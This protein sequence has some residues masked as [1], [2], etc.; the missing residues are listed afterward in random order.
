MNQLLKIITILSLMQSIESIGLGADLKNININLTKT[1]RETKKIQEELEKKLESKLEDIL[2]EYKKSNGLISSDNFKS[3]YGDEV[4]KMIRSAVQK[5]YIA[6]SN[7]VGKAINEKEIFL[8]DKD[9]ANIKQEANRISNSFWYQTNQMLR[10]Y[11]LNKQEKTTLANKERTVTPAIV[12]S[13]VASTATFGTLQKATIAKLNQ[14]P[15]ATITE[16]RILT[17][18]TQPTACPI[19]RQYEG[20][21][22]YEDDP[23]IIQPIDD[24]HPNCQCR[25]LLSTETTE[26]TQ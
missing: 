13:V 11:D 17:F 15:P 25:L 1:S 21:E 2:K 16:K 7:Y 10:T 14:L 20:T 6:G 18:K 9:N 24:T 12:S 22:W 19:C 26:L 5:A 8:T 3:R 4:Y 23:F